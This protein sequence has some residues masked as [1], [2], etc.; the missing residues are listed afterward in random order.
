MRRI[1]AARGYSGLSQPA[2]AEALGVSKDTLARIERGERDLLGY[3]L[4]GF[5]AT[6]ADATSL[7][8]A[9]FS[10]DFEQLPRLE[11]LNAI[12]G[13]AAYVQQTAAEIRR[14]VRELVAREFSKLPVEDQAR[15]ANAI[16]DT[17]AAEL[18]QI[19]AAAREADAAIDAAAEDLEGNARG[20]AQPGSARGG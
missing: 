7:P 15:L 1:R 2:L 18:E 4:R 8:P 6:V 20:G 5:I 10:V 11:D 14:E 19:E 3:E 12:P 13:V 16:G 17:T 9:F